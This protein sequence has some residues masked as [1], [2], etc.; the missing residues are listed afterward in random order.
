VRTGLQVA[1]LA[2]ITAAPLAAQAPTP[3]RLSIGD[4]LGRA[5]SAAEGIGIAEAGVRG[6][7]ARVRQTRSAM[8]PQLSGAVTYTRTLETQFAALASSSD[9][10]PP[11]APTGCGRFRPNPAL[12]LGE[13]LDSL[14]RGLD[15]TA[16]GSGIDFS[17]LPFGR[18]NQWNLGLEASQLLFDRALPARIRAAKAGADRARAALDAERART[19]L[20]AA[21]TYYDAQ[22]ASRL[23][24]IAESTLVQAE[25]TY[26]ETALAR[27]VGT[28]AEFDL[29]RASV[30]RDNQKP[31]VIQRRTQRDQAFL[32]L[33]QLL[34][35][36]PDTPVE[37]TTPLADTSAV[38]LP[39]NVRAST[40]TAVAMRA[41]VREAAAGVDAA[42]GTLD[43]ARGSRWPIVRLSSSYAKIT[44]PDDV[45]RWERMLTDWTVSVRA[46]VPL[47]TG[48]RIKG[49]VEAAQA[50][51]DIARLRLRQAREAASRET[52]SAVQ[53]LDAAT[54]AFEASTGT[55]EQ[56]ARA[57]QIAEV[58][59]REGLSTLTDLADARLQRQQADANRAQ[60]ARDLQV[61]RL[62]VLL[63]RDL[64]LGAVT[65]P[66]AF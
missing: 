16:N 28:A 51:A 41:P 55:A 17:N 64:P 19:V 9:S 43:A 53:L 5:D 11:P 61:A 47:F 62:R 37:L 63:L 2:I 49:E 65:A 10:A 12:P 24:A 56:A 30:A 58:R 14:E 60:A 3:V 54:A 21:Q 42:E 27:R 18:P 48:G 23:L 34:D 20:D 52:A 50:E 31:V 46:S 22:L 26:D 45:F 7:G 29:L 57:Y 40:D 32:R 33:R 36:A 1:L 35:L 6:A 8:L 4:V 15:C 13:R 38:P 25:R 44:F 66:G 59:V 39:A